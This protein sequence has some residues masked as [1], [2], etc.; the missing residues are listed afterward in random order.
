MHLL[1]LCRYLLGFQPL[2][3]LQRHLER[4]RLQL[5]LRLQRPWPQ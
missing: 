2:Q 1:L 4:Q 5:W 3:G